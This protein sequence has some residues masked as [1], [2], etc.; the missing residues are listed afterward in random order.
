MKLLLCTVISLF[1]LSVSPIYGKLKVCTTTSFVRDLV[2]NIGKN[3]VE[4]ESLMGPG[5][6]PHLYKASIRDLKKLRSADLIFYNGLHLEGRMTDVFESM[7][8]G[9]KPTYAVTQDL[10]H[11][12][13]IGLNEEGTLHDPHVWFDPTLWA[14]CAQT[15]ANLLEKHDAAN[16]AKY[17]SHAKNYIKSLEELNAWA[18]VEINKLPSQ[19]RILITSHDAYNYFGNAYKFQ[20]IGVQGVSTASEA[21]LADIV[22]TID[23]IKKHEVKA[24]FVESS[25]SPATIERIASGSGA[26]IGG[27]LFSDSL[28][29]SELTKTYIGTFKHNLITILSHLK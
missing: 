12:T 1:I 9:K 18:N 25:V 20:V 19:K 8:A 11:S 26:V 27:Q 13:L 24:I 5:V 3:E 14:Q 6:D 17:Q 22:S 28:G 10:H 2:E 15:V 16:G 23:F 4:V 7:T 29:D 21:G